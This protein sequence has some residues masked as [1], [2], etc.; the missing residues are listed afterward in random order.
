MEAARGV[1]EPD[2][3]IAPQEA[4]GRG[5]PEQ[6]VERSP[7]GVA[8]E[9]PRKDRG[10]AADLVGDVIVHDGAAPGVGGPLGLR[11]LGLGGLRGGPGAHAVGPPELEMWTTHRTGI[12]LRMEA[13][14]VPS[15]LATTA[16]SAR[17]TVLARG[18]ASPLTVM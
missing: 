18:V 17:K 13:P 6:P 2:E 15:R 1:A 4:D 11:R 9:G 7:E 5:H 8:V 12:R 14:V 10:R 16:P 3:E